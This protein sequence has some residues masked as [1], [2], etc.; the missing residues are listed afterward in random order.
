LRTF[1]QF[2]LEDFAKSST[3]LPPFGMTVD[4]Q[5]SLPQKLEPNTS[6][7]VFSYWHPF[8][9]VPGVHLPGSSHARKRVP[10]SPRGRVDLGPLFIT[11]S[12]SDIKGKRVEGLR[13]ARVKESHP[14]DRAL[15]PLRTSN[16]QW[17]IEP[18]L[19]RTIDGVQNWMDRL[20][21]LGN[22]VVPQQA[23][24]AFQRLAGLK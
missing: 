15:L 1:P 4:G 17:E 5:L 19:R 24:E 14:L 16:G 21:C 3:P 7:G 9:R 13:T 12:A 8:R 10:M 20:K 2:A 23:R 11:E 6:D 18:D 22:A